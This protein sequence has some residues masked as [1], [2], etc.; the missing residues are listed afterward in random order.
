MMKH[1]NRCKTMLD[2]EMF[3]LRNK[4]GTMRSAYCKPCKNEITRDW[5]RRKAQEHMSELAPKFKGLDLV[6]KCIAR[7]YA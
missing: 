2:I 6:G 4:G 3:S 1:C 5:C 7:W